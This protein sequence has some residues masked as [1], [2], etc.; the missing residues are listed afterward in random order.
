M[1]FQQQLFTQVFRSCIKKYVCIRKSVEKQGKMDTE[2]ENMQ[3]L[4]LNN[5]ELEGGT[6]QID[7]ATVKK[8]L[9]VL[10]HQFYGELKSDKTWKAFSSN[11]LVGVRS[12]IQ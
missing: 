12:G 8:G 10:L 3:S 7:L 11:T 2:E 9:A 6:R 4:Q 5:E 1:L